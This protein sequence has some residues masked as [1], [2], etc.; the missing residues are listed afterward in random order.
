MKL[1][2]TE[3]HPSLTNSLWISEGLNQWV[4]SSSSEYVTEKVIS[5]SNKK[6]DINQN[7]SIAWKFPGVLRCVV[8]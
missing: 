3:R 5:T 4:N 1:Q 6:M 2:V 8:V 7:C